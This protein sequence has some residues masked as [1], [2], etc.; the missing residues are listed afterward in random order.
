MRCFK[1]YVSNI[2]W[3][4]S[5]TTSKS[6]QCHALQKSQ[7]PIWQKLARVYNTEFLTLSVLVPGDCSPA[8]DGRLLALC[9]A[10][11]AV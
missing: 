6:I 3:K 9:A 1:K 8:N 10:I 11:A 5:T 2:K 4:I 7:V